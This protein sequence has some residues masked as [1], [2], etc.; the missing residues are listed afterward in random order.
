MTDSAGRPVTDASVIVFSTDN[1]YWRN[2]MGHI[3][4]ALPD[5]KGHFTLAGLPP[6]EYAAASVSTAPTD[7][8]VSFLTK[9]LPIAVRFSLADGEHKV[10][11]VRRVR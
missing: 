7:D 8:V 10:V 1:R 9:L 5:A 6:G 2:T 4:G 11:D 3:K